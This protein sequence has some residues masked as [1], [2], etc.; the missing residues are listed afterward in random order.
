MAEAETNSFRNLSEISV[1]TN[2]VS[3]LLNADR[4][5]QKDIGVITPYNCQKENIKA[6]FQAQKW[7]DIE[8]GS[9]EYFR[10]REKQIVIA[11]MVRSDKHFGLGFV[12]E[13]KV[14]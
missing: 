7:S 13:N 6:T 14:K 1:V 8:V 9:V 3:T 2:Y 10:G 5:C 12:R 11:S 4:C